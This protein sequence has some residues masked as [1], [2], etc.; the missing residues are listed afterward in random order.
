MHHPL[1]SCLL[2][3][4]NRARFIGQAIG[5][6]LQQ[7]Y[8]NKELIIL[9][10]KDADLPAGFE[11]P[12]N[13]SLICTGNI[14]LG[15]KRNYAINTV[16]GDLIA[17]WDDDDIYHPKRLS[18]Q[19]APLLT[20]EADITGFDDILF[21]ETGKNVCWSGSPPVIRSM[22]DGGIACGT[23]V[24]RKEIW[25]TLTE[26]PDVSY[27]EEGLFLLQAL[28]NGARLKAIDGKDLY[29]YVR[30]QSNTFRFRKTFFNSRVQW[31]QTP[32]PEW[33]K[34]YAALYRGR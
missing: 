21:Y 25:G 14:K 9:H 13:V 12:P 33:A 32:L 19:I 2:P 16:K 24:F 22:F 5:F 15:A 17:Q 18:K 26:Y 4:E 31:R 20:G 29:I 28:Q 7:D 11:Y 8:P 3:T 6:F 23:M 1:V 27:R 34:P 30:H 10:S